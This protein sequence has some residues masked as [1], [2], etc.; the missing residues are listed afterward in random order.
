V[1]AAVAVR[2]RLP[3][4]PVIVSVGL[5]VGVLALDE[6]VSVVLPLPVTV[7]GLNDATA[8]VGSPLTPKLT[9]PAKPF[10]GVTATLKVVDAPALMLRDPGVTASEKSAAGGGAAPAGTICRPL[11]GDRSVPSVAV[12]GVAVIVKL[13][14]VIAYF[15][16]FPAEPAACTN[17]PAKLLCGAS[18]TPRVVVAIPGPLI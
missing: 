2:L 1:S 13:D 14:P 6:T 16:K 17:V 3:L 12:P 18:I 11:I 5:P 15:T 4:V 9:T 10:A 8:P 7:V